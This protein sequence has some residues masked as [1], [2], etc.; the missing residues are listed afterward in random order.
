MYLAGD[1]GITFAQFL[2]AFAVAED[3]VPA[4]DINEHG[5]TYFAGES[6]LL[7]V[8]AVLRSQRDAASLQP[9]ADKG[10][11][12]KQRRR[13]VVHSPGPAPPPSPIRALWPCW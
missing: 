13:C 2:A 8:V 4:A 1:K 5:G 6:T 7:L 11:V 12:G 10:R 3:D 9:L